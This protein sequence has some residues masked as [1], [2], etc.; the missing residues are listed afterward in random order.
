M[1]VTLK[2]FGQ[3]AEMIKGDSL[4]FEIKSKLTL[5]D[6]H[7]LWLSQHPDR[8]TRTDSRRSQWR[9]AF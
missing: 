2:F 7:D 5:K 3:L 4:D 6:F 9:R 8:K 1:T